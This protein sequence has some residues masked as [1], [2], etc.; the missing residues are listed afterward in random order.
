MVVERGGF[1]FTVYIFSPMFSTQL[2]YLHPLV[3]LKVD[4]SISVFF[5]WS[6]GGY[7]LLSI[8][9]TYPAKF[10]MVAIYTLFTTGGF[11]F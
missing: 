8:R 5:L 4:F 11:H 3:L 2:R 7:L 6:N 10:T 9:H 1:S